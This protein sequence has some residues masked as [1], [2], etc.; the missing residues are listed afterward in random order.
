[1]LR[2][3]MNVIKCQYEPLMMKQQVADATPLRYLDLDNDPCV[4]YI[5]TKSNKHLNL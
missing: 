1:M 4:F 2:T 3:C 5:P